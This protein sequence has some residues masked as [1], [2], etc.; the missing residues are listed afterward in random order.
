M[1]PGKSCL[2]ANTRRLAPANLWGRIH[3]LCKTFEKVLGIVREGEEEEGDGEQG[4]WQEAQ[5]ERAR[6]RSYLL[7]QEGV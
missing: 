2:L 3:F 4:R 6:E 7:N 1:A 5:E